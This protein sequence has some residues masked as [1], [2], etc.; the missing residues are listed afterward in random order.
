MEVIQNGKIGAFFGVP[1]VQDDSVKELR[2]T[3]DMIEFL[4]SSTEWSTAYQYG[5]K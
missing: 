5:D 1:I 4:K 2:L 3:K